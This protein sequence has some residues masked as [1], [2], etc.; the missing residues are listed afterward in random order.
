MKR[1]STY[2]NAYSDARHTVVIKPSVMPRQLRQIAHS[3]SQALA[4]ADISEYTLSQTMIW[5]FCWSDISIDS[6]TAA[7]NRSWR[8]ARLSQSEAAWHLV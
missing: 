4:N 8:S 7:R 6:Q 2:Y 1:K 5:S 3:P